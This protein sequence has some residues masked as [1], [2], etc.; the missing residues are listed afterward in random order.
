MV[1]TLTLSENISVLPGLRIQMWLSFALAT[2]RTN[3]RCQ[4]GGKACQISLE[5]T[6]HLLSRITKRGTVWAAAI[7]IRS[8]LNLGG[9]RLC[10]KIEE[11]GAG[12]LFSIHQCL[13][14]INDKIALR[15]T[16][17]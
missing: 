4:L 3:A 10:I 17:R 5:T 13:E 9:L 1:K 11:L 2:L 7:K 8:K 15:F 16:E 6:H 12:G 14:F